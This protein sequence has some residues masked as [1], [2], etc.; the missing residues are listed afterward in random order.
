MRADG[1]DP[2]QRHGGCAA[3][4]QAGVNATQ[5]ASAAKA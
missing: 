1:A 4:A 2:Q 5:R 3:S